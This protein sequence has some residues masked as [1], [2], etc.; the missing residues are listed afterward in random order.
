MPTLDVVGALQVIVGIVISVFCVGAVPWAI[1]VSSRLASIETHLRTMHWLT[2]AVNDIKA[3]IGNLERQV[4]VQ[5]ATC[6]VHK[7]RVRE[8]QGT[9]Q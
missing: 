7:E 6:I 9:D 5:Q 1:K 4:A 3:R 8:T 2:E